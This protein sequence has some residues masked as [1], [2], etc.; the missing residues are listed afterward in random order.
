MRDK[1][2]EF[3]CFFQVGGYSFSFVLI[4]KRKNQL[5]FF[6]IFCIFVNETVTYYKIYQISGF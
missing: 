1:D 6:D 3:I 4:R 2:R 5:V